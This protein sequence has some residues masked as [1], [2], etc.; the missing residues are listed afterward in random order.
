ML[1]TYFADLNAHRFHAAWL[2]EAPC[3]VSYT[4]SN[5]PGAPV[6]SAGF[7]GRGK[8]L[9]PRGAALRHPILAAAHVTSIKRLHIAILDRNHIAAFAV[10]GWFRFDYS[11]APY[12]NDTHK[13]G[14]HMVKIAMWQCNGH[15]GV[16]PTY[17]ESSGGGP[18]NWP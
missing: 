8:W 4:V 18:L 6:G 11:A 15:W 9:A 5:G 12:A 16:E 13:T 14:H 2:L 3:G 17:W 7:A 1:W 10:S